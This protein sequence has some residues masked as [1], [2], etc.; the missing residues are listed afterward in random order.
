M[1]ALISLGPDL[2]WQASGGLFDWTLEFLIERLN[3]AEATDRLREIV[4]NNLGSL[5]LSDLPPQV[6]QVALHLLADQLVPLGE[7]T[8]PD[9]D[10]KDQAIS[11]LRGLA[12]LAEHV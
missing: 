9:N 12:T 10:Y 5:W 7:R 2:D 11:Q 1:A 6:G 3:N 4:D 8:M